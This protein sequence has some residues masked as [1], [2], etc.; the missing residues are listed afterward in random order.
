MDSLLALAVEGALFRSK[1]LIRCGRPALVRVSSPVVSLLARPTRQLFP[2][3]E[4]VEIFTNQFLII[5]SILRVQ[6][7]KQ[8]FAK[9]ILP[10]LLWQVTR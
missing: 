10:R 8:I 9:L 7:A 4:R 6:G 3:R 2:L 1:S 5:R